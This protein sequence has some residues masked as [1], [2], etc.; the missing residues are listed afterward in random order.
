MAYQ[1]YSKHEASGEARGGH[2]I[3]QMSDKV[4]KLLGLSERK[5]QES[6]REIITHLRDQLGDAQKGGNEVAAI[7]KAEA[8]DKDAANEL[9]ERHMV[10]WA[11][12]G[13]LRVTEMFMRE[14]IGMTPR[15]ECAPNIKVSDRDIINLAKVFDEKATV[16]SDIYEQCTPEE[17]SGYT[18]DGP[19]R[20]Y[21]T[22]EE[23]LPPGKDTPS[24]DLV[25]RLRFFIRKLQDD[26]PEF[27]AGD[28]SPLEAAVHMYTLRAA[29]VPLTWDN[30]NCGSVSMEPMR[31]P[32]GYAPCLPWTGVGR[33]GGLMLGQLFISDNL[34]KN[35]PG[36]RIKLGTNPSK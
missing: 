15:L 27:A 25:S 33:Y 13:V 8:I 31:I 12:S 9:F 22:F 29:D 7:V 32:G 14:G 19:W 6:Y 30:T 16:D 4:L 10:E 26:F 35:C 28:L 5:E 2:A 34:V 21:V 23:C 3:G 18:A 11:S 36:V 17:L 20:M 24:I 1:P